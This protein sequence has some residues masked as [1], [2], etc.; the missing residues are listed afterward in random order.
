MQQIVF[1]HV[2]ANDLKHG[3]IQIGINDVP[4]M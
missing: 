3:M 2:V 4:R 1:S